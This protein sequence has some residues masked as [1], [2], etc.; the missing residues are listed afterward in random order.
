MNLINLE[1]NKE[2][3]FVLKVKYKH[4]KKVSE[5]LESLNFKIYNP[6]IT[7]SK[8]WSDR[9]KKIKV[10]AIPGVIFIKTSLKEKNK[11]FCS[12][13]IKSWLFENNKPV[14]V[15]Q[16]ELKLFINNL[17]N[18]NK[19]NNNNNNNNVINDKKIKLGDVVFL[20]HL[21]VNAII[22]KLDLKNIWA[23]VEKA[24]LTLKLIR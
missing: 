3:W 1:F 5:L 13:S 23:S 8:K 22:N 24:N 16:S 14:N 17:N 20:K 19:K 15:N 7:V 10:P 4:E 9:I 21:R 18:L 12:S 6:T 2:K 11:V